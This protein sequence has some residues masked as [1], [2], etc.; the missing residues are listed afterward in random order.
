MRVD[1]GLGALVECDGICI[2][3]GARGVLTS[4]GGYRI[5]A[6]GEKCTAL[7]S[8]VAGGRE[9]NALERS[10]THLAGLAV[11]REAED[12][13]AR[14]R[15]RDLQIEAIAVGTHAGLRRV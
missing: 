1:V 12:P 7:G 10:K 8:L 11:K 13:G 3:D 9:A 5:N 4:A 15:A 14:T 6:V 2:G